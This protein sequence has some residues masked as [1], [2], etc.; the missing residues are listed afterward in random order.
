MSERERRNAIDGAAVLG[1]LT[2]LSV[3]LLLLRF[4][5]ELK[6]RDWGGWFPFLAVAAWTAISWLVNWRDARR[7]I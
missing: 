5:P 7:G 4:V 6:G 3:T 2:G 1:F